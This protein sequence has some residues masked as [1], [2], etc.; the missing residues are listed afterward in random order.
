MNALAHEAEQLSQ[1]GST[2]DKF[3]M[4]VSITDIKKN[5]PRINF[6]KI[7][8]AKLY[9]FDNSLKS[10]NITRIY[11]DDNLLSMQLPIKR[12]ATEISYESEN[13]NP[14]RKKVDHDEIKVEKIES[15]L[16]LPETLKSEP[17]SLPQ[18]I[19][20]EL[21]IEPTL[22]KLEQE[23]AQLSKKSEDEDDENVVLPQKKDVTFNLEAQIIQD[24]ENIIHSP[25]TLPL[26]PIDE[27]LVSSSSES[28]TVIWPPIKEKKGKSS[29]LKGKKKKKSGKTKPYFLSEKEESKPLADIESKL[30]NLQEEDV[31]TPW[32]Y[33]TH[34]TVGMESVFKGGLESELIDSPISNDFIAQ[35]VTPVA[36]PDEFLEKFGLQSTEAETRE[37][38]GVS[39]KE[40]IESKLAETIQP[41]KAFAPKIQDDVL[42]QL[43]KEQEF[44]NVK[45]PFTVGRSDK[46]NFDVGTPGKVEK[47]FDKSGKTKITPMRI[48]IFGGL[49]VTLGY[50]IWNQMFSNLI[51]YNP[52]NQ[53]K[54]EI[55]IR[56]LFKQSHK[57]KSDSKP[58][59]EI[60]YQ[61][62]KDLNEKLLSPITEG[63]RMKLI[64]QARESLE[65]RLDP[66]GQELPPPSESTADSEKGK[67]DKPLPDVNVQRKQVELVGV[68]SLQNKNLALVNIYTVD[69]GVSPNDD[70]KV[71]E[72]KLK[73]A[74]GMAVPN[75]MEVSVLD[76]VEDWNI[77]VINKSKSRSDDP[78]IELVKG[79]KKFKL[80]VG[81]KVLLPEEKPL[82]EYVPLESEA[83]K[84]DSEKTDSK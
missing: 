48:I 46:V 4:S 16:S 80:K 29:S 22:K 39:D 1:L 10:K 67:G 26:P 58:K 79:D 33:Q 12:Q 13:V 23:E 44:N 84:N 55:I 74:L 28:A 63:E 73:T 40:V 69:Y 38:V 83:E 50:L 19:E 27:N 17:K 43:I 68:I 47:M 70:K 51:N 20:S 42:E 72:E 60:D 11:L 57:L 32:S 2:F 64:E 8:L 56:D 81:Q 9:D 71:R 18:E 78:T 45:T 65:Q 82:P 21:L 24:E 62:T 15:V 25:S 75:R 54:D 52:E 49:T 61:T 5:I 14:L 77:R 3:L 76:P 41:F 35:E 59:K 31:K 66:F 36:E 6:K 53:A 37:K 7:K 30:Q 34:E